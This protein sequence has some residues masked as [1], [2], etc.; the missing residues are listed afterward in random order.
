MVNTN[1]IISKYSSFY[2]QNST[3]FHE[4][5]IKRGFICQIDKRLKISIEKIYEVALR[6]I[7]YTTLSVSVCLGAMLFSKIITVIVVVSSIGL[8]TYQYIQS[9]KVFYNIYK[10]RALAR[11]YQVSKQFFDLKL[12]SRTN[13]EIAYI[14]NNSKTSFEQKLKFVSEAKQS[15]EISFNFAGGK[16]LQSLLKVVEEKHNT[17]SGFKT[18]ILVSEDLLRKKDKKTLENLK[19][20]YPESFFYIITDRQLDIEE[21]MSI[22]N[23]AKMLIVDGHYSSVG[24][25]GVESHLNQQKLVEE[26]TVEDKKLGIFNDNTRDCDIFLKGDISLSIRQEFYK[27]YWIWLYK[28]NKVPSTNEGKPNTV[29]INHTLGSR[30]F[31][32]KSKV[33]ENV[34]CEFLV[35]GP[36]DVENNAITLKIVDMVNSAKES[37][38][39]GN[40][41]FN[42]DR[43]ISKALSKAKERGVSVIGV[44]NGYG[45]KHHPMHM[46]FPAVN[47]QNYN[48]LTQ[49]YER[50][51]ANQLYHKKVIV[52]DRTKS[53][54]MS[55]N[56]GMKSG[57]CDYECGVY[58]EDARIAA[59]IIN[60]IKKD[61]SLADLIYHSEK[62]IDKRPKITRYIGTVFNKLGKVF[63]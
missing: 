53:L 47:H 7:F 8:L 19:N 2:S 34:D 16:N 20:K 32:K 14:A 31:I 3:E 38:D 56:L 13:A 28:M 17:L 52:V 41:Y 21:P 18:H 44:F 48:C 15:V 12:E 26:Q 6:T 55:Y 4:L 5:E 57:F 1:N 39:I 23:H 33:K 59:D 61:I 42:P 54:T 24:G 9:G 60:G 45:W 43:R 50:S 63:F 22:E 35:C 36:E 58:S 30:A 40:L 25:S 46:H 29:D 11:A 37:I 27:L 10:L 51:I 62:G 49:A